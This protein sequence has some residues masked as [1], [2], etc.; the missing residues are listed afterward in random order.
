MYDLA[1]KF[2]E[3]DALIAAI[4]LALITFVPLW[5]TASR[6]ATPTSWIQDLSF[7]SALLWAAMVGADLIGMEII[8]GH[9]LPQITER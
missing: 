7:I 3:G 1:L 4:Y 2:A 6:L 5:L 9:N 8:R